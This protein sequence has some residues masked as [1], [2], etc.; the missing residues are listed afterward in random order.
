[1]KKNKLLF[2]TPFAALAA[3]TPFITSCAKPTLNAEEV[4]NNLF[5]PLEGE[6][7]DPPSGYVTIIDILNGMS[8]SERKNELIYD[9]FIGP[10]TISIENTD[11]SIYDLYKEKYLTALVNIN[12]CTLEPSGSGRAGSVSASFRGYI[13]FVFTKSFGDYKVNDYILITY[14]FPKESTRPTFIHNEWGLQYNL[15]QDTN[16]AIQS[17]VGFIESRKGGID[18]PLHYI[19]GPVMASEDHP[20][21]KNWFALV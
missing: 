9:L 7:Q 5:A 15:D 12:E 20:N 2:L 3:T 8:K 13:N 10:T 6:K 19:L 16:N 1:M 14:L 17:C 4:I 11:K 21:T 18:Q